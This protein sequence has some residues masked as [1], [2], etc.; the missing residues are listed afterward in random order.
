MSDAPA[1]DK[2]DPF[3]EQRQIYQLLSQE[4]RH[5]VLQYI[6]G[7]P[8][9]LPSLDE[10]AHMIPKNKAAIRDQLQVLR[11]ADI[12]ERYE[13]PPNEDSRELP[14]QFYGLT[15][16]GVEILTEYNYL[17]GLPIARALYDNTRLSEKSQRHLDAPRPELPSNVADA[18]TIGPSDERANYSRLEQYI[19]DRKGGTHSTDDQVETAKAFHQA[20]IDPDHEGI[21]RAELLDELELELEYQPKTVL[22]HLVDLGILEATTPPGPNVFAISER[23]D[24][25][26]NGRVTEEAD[27]NLD[28][29]VA[30]IDDELQSVE[31]G[32]EAAELSGPQT[33]VSAPSVALAD[34]AGR[35]IRSILAA[36]FDVAPERVVEFLYSGDPVDRLN[37]AVDAIESS[38]E[39]TKSE[40]Y[41]R[42]VFLNQAYRY[43]LTE[44]AMNLC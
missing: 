31:L 13:H 5:L 19:E 25:I 24:E 22:D 15:E 6:L 44:K 3:E 37:A 9:H 40:E 21:K 28:A 18:L 26:V 1:A 33:A 14:S 8:A 30:H 20:G 10:L 7:H 4:T 2:R 29:L 12:I 17:R 23:I 27:E 41:G 38:A 42:I 16:Y 43:R 39:V 32:D 11:E 34:G 35:T 36:E